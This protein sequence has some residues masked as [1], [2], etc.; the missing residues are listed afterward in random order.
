MARKQSSQIWIRGMRHKEFYFEGHYHDELWLNGACLWKKLSGVFPSAVSAVVKAAWMAKI[1]TTAYSLEIVQDTSADTVSMTMTP[2]T[3][4]VPGTPVTVS[5][6]FADHS[7]ERFMGAGHAGGMIIAAVQS[8]YGREVTDPAVWVSKDGATFTRYT[9][10]TWSGL[11]RP[12]GITFSR[13]P[14]RNTVSAGAIGDI[15]LLP[16]E[17]YSSPSAST[18]IENISYVMIDTNAG[19]SKIET[20]P[21]QGNSY[22]YADFFND[23]ASGALYALKVYTEVSNTRAAV[24]GM[25]IVEITGASISGGLTEATVMTLDPAWVSS[26]SVSGIAPY[27]HAVHGTFFYRSGNKLYRI[28]GTTGDRTA[29]L[30][31]PNTYYCCVGD[32]AH[33]G[34]DYLV[35]AYNRSGPSWVGYRSSDGDTWTEDATLSSSTQYVTDRGNSVW[36]DNGIYTGDWNGQVIYA[37]E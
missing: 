25:E 12:T 26:S 29:V 10:P 2:W 22:F 35:L 4:G 30:T 11:D 13:T 17:H 23:L 1:G 21:A 9:L 31:F 15:V 6:S 19:A 36:A 27:L 8:Y 5:G 7:G 37:A 24:T 34:T 18:S 28:D 14:N 33:D 32:V 20:K 16:G 3:A